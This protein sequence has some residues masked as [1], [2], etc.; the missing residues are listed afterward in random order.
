M[1]ESSGVNVVG[2]PVST[3][4][5]GRRAGRL[6]PAGEGGRGTL[7]GSLGSRDA[8]T[9]GEVLSERLVGAAVALLR[10]KPDRGARGMDGD[11][12]GLGLF[13]A[14]DEP[15]QGRFA[16]TVGPNNGRAC[17]GTDPGGDV[18]QDWARAVAE[19]ETA[20]VDACGG[21]RSRVGS[22][23]R[24]RRRLIAARHFVD[25]RTPD[26]PQKWCVGV[27]KVRADGLIA[28]AGQSM[29]MEPRGV[30]KWTATRPGSSSSI[31]SKRKSARSNGSS[32]QAA[33]VLALPQIS[34]ASMPIGTSG[35][36]LGW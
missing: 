11:A 9:A 34:A 19:A 7:H 29:R 36:A 8:R 25:S 4:D 32:S 21:H 24:V 10:K 31:Q 16:H 18:V 1:L 30:E 28:A 12:A 17:P 20:Q 33:I 14:G 15:Q 26:T 3:G 23:P 27:H 2:C 22:N 35:L 13:E 5:N 6:V